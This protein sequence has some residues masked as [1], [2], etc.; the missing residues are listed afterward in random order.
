MPLINNLPERYESGFNELSAI[1]TEEFAAIKEG[2]NAA[3]NT[4]S[5]E[6]LS[7]EIE[8][9]EALKEVDIP[10]ILASVGSLIPFIEKNEM[11]D[12][13][14]KDIV[15]LSN[16][17][18]DFIIDNEAEFVERLTFLL[19]DKHIFYA[20]KATDL[21]N[22][23]GNVFILS[24]IVSD[25]RPVFGLDVNEAPSAGVILHTLNIHYQSNDE[26]YH[27]DISLTLSNEDLIVL[28][29]TIARAEKKQEALQ[30]IFDK[31]GME[32]LTN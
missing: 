6:K 32:N 1:T 28:K 29:D 4:H 18:E 14:V 5:L 24:R 17:S 9:I 23:Y 11:I 22:N 13:I 16:Y 8:K 3:T 26:P 31:A 25:V 12:E 21:M 20:S 27:K 2:I 10:D 15:E 19:K 7:N 30:T